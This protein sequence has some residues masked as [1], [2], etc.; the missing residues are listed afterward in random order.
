MSNQTYYERNREK[1]LAYAKDRTSKIPI[2]ER[3]AYHRSWYAKNKEKLKPILNERAKKDYWNKRE[4]KQK[5]AKGYRDKIKDE[6][7]LEYGNKCAC[8]GEVERAFLTLEHI[9]R[10][11]KLHRD[12]VGHTVT[13]QLRDL[14]KRGWPK[15]DYE[16]LCFN[17]NRATWE[18]GICPHRRLNVSR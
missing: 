6:F 2:E 17:C 5:Q 4:F 16:I 13:S 7:F 1:L 8:C 14:K 3:R 12:T 18:Q 9:N 11:G 15:G 10:D